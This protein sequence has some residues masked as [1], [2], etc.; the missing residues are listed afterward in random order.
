MRL[1][2]TISYPTVAV[3]CY[4]GLVYTAHLR[5]NPEQSKITPTLV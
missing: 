4:F 3:Q 5:F 1:C 2:V